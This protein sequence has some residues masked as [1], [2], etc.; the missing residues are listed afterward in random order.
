[1]RRALTAL[2]ACLLAGVSA[3]AVTGASGQT[4]TT[5][6]P[7][8]VTTS[9]A[10]PSDLGSTITVPPLQ[11]AQAPVTTPADPSPSTTT[12]T[13]SPARTT[14]SAPPATTSSRHPTTSTAT[15][16]TAPAPPTDTPSRRSTSAHAPSST[17]RPTPSTTSIAPTSRRTTPATSTTKPATTKPTTT[18]PTTTPP[19]P[20]P[21]AI[22]VTVGNASQIITVVASSSSATTATLTAWQRSASGTWSVALGPYPA[23]IGS[24]GIGP[25]SEYHSRTPQGTFTLTQAFGRLA[26]PGT[27]LPYHLSQP[28]DWWVS[29]VNS[30]TY[31][32]LQNCAKSACPFNTSVSEHI[33]YEVPYYNYAVVMDVNRWPAVPGAGS[34]FFLHVSPYH[35]PTAG[36]VSIDQDKL[37]KV[38]RWLDPAQH[39]RIADGID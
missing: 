18:K 37:I 20:L 31:N 1:M 27:A 26:N 7:A 38:M 28:N 23:W 4:L 22:P 39:P 24:E 29:D 14:S 25:S 17:A 12:S 6:P 33:Y 2:G 5:S 30:P 8:T 11:A 32:T 36:C 3:C 16:S 13:L 19:P 9:S 35:A 21:F 15:T 34:A 10:Q